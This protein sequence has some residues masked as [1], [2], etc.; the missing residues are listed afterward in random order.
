[1]STVASAVVDL[2]TAR[3]W[4]TGQLVA[5]AYSWPA[6]F[7]LERLDD[8]A[9]RVEPLLFVSQG[10]QVV[11]PDGL[12]RLYGGIRRRVTKYQGPGFL[13]GGAEENLQPGD[14][15]IATRPGV[16]ALMVDRSFLGSTVSAAFSAYRFP[17][18]D[19]AYWVW[20]VM[21]STSGQR[22]LRSTMTDSL[23]SQRRRIGDLPLPWPE[24]EVRSRLGGTIAG[25][26]SGTHRATDEAAETW[27]STADLRSVEWRTAMA[28][29]DPKQLLNGTRLEDMGIEISA[30][31]TYNRS[32]GLTAPAKGRLPVLNGGVLANRPVTRWLSETDGSSIAEPG[33]VLVAAVGD[34][35]NARIAEERVV[36]DASVYRLRLPKGMSAAAVVAFLNGQTGYGLRRI[37]LTGSLIQRVTLRDLKQLRVP[38]GALNAREAEGPLKPLAEQLELVLWTR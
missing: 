24:R 38:E 32:A 2:R 28:T 37:L 14:L 19:D 20:A 17:N 10:T 18:I 30:G 6:D 36:I 1:M 21:S 27:W 26:E 3:V 35:S 5:S 31:R 4:D 33:D 13:V 34:R 11:T 12:D 15:L 22:F 25:I 9:M 29:P 23:S 8:V 16:P 7:A